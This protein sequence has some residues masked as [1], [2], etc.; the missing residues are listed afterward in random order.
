[1][2]E[3]SKNGYGFYKL[4]EIITSRE[5]I[6]LGYRNL[7]SNKGSNTK[8][9][10]NKTIKDLEVLNNDKLINLVR[11]K[12]KNYHPKSVRRV[13]IPKAN[14]DRRPLGIP[15]IED[16][17]I[18]QCVLQVLEPICEAKFYNYS[19]GFRPNR[20]AKHAVARAYSLAQINKLNY[21]VDIDL[22]G[23]FD[24]VK[25][26]KL[27]KQLWTL[28]IKDKRLISIISKMLKAE[29]KGEGKPTRGTPQGGILSPIL[30]NIVLNELDWWIASQWDNFP[31]KFEYKHKGNKHVALRNTR[32]KEMQL[33][34]YADDFKIFC[35]YKSDANKIYESVTKWLR[36]RLKLDINENK[37]KIVDL[38]K[39]YSEFL[40]IKFKLNKKNNKKVIQS[41]ICDKAIGKITSDLK[42]IMK[43]IR[44]YNYSEY[45][46]RL[47]SMILGYHNYYNMATNVSRD[48]S[49]IQNRL[50]KRMKNKRAVTKTG[51]VA[52]FIV[53]KYKKYKGERVYLRNVEIIPI[54][55]VKFNKPMQFGRNI[56]SY[57]AIG[58]KEIHKN[59]DNNIIDRLIYIMNNPSKAGSIEFNDNKIA[60]Y[61]KQKG[62]CN[63]LNVFLEPYEMDCHH[64]IP[65]SMGGAD[66][67]KNLIYIS[68]KVHKLIH[69]NSKE[70][71]EKYLQE[72][73]INKEILKRINELRKLAG[74]NKITI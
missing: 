62:K 70:T 36:E 25:H 27:L 63:V 5:N 67:Y 69:A 35:R 34:R 19:F 15:T 60:L 49:K 6:L 42:H 58:R 61:S 29:I 17:L 10:D 65:K 14:G 40:G 31:T 56:C 20:S 54:Y 11:N 3:K 74:L 38:E 16:R 7:K 48:F 64:K 59:I 55:G 43:K 23:F 24:N 68:R 28:G 30:A 21:C 57:T 32:L 73:S 33:V 39:E 8:G 2:Y 51:N 53:E 47:N 52:D 46:K 44:R 72:I 13:Y 45:P 4:Y 9:T 12:L 22:K 1:M 18:Q 37:S 71:I 41:N 66:E 50:Y 26:G